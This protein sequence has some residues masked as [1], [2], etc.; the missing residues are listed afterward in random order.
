MAGETILIVEDVPASLKFAAGV[1]RSAGYKVQIASTAEQALSILRFLRPQLILVDFGLPGMDGLELTA[2]VKQDTRL[3]SAI[4]VALTACAT[5]RDEERARQAG[6]DGYLTKPIEAPALAARI[7]AYL[8]HGADALPTP[9]ADTARTAALE[10]PTDNAAFGLP[11]AEM[12]EL[13][14]AFLTDGK[15]LSRQLLASLEGAFDEAKAARTVHQWTGTGGLLGFPHISTLSREVETVLRTPPWTVARLRGPVT[16][17]ARAFSN[18]TAAS[19]GASQSMVRE[20]TG[21]RVALIGLSGEDAER[22]C[23]ALEQVG[24][25]PRLFEAG[26]SPYADAV[27]NCQV[28]F[29][30]VR[31]GTKNCKWLLPAAARLPVLP[32]IFIGEAEQLLSLN[33]KV[34]A[35]ACGLLMDGWLPE[36]ALMRL[37]LAVSYTPPAIRQPAAAG[38]G[39]LVIATS[40]ESLRA[41]VQSRLHEHGLHCQLAANGPDTF[42]LLRHLRPPVAVL[43]VDMDGLEVLAAIRTESIPVRT[44]LLTSQQQER[45]ILLGFSL[46]AE[47]YLV[48]PFS[49]GELV[50]RLKRLLA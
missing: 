24:A 30:H 3:R 45:E 1:L 47:D 34:Q 19:D 29:V 37:R 12:A 50:V 38:T 16:N 32:T 39:E 13:R 4:V 27:G 25:R 21:M 15:V 5:P 14:E 49:A 33:P 31:P 36:E 8:D 41:L 17:L 2:R 35:R 28:V 22:M 20:L 7:R 43:D 48:Q 10:A 23:G 6:C 46:G 26:Q 40:D 44:I 42:V 11:E 18:P 9:A